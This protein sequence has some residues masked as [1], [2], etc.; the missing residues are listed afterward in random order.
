MYAV[1][2]VEAAVAAA[3]AAVV[4]VAVVEAMQVV[5]VAA[6]VDLH[7]LLLPTAMHLQAAPA[8]VHVVVL[9]LVPSVPRIAVSAS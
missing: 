1:L 9:I 3:A 5:E 4:A 2:L 8:V 6:E 7:L